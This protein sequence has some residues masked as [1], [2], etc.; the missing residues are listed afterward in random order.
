MMEYQEHEMTEWRK[1]ASNT[2]RW[3]VTLNI[4]KY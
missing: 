4:E 2:K 1:I 3:N